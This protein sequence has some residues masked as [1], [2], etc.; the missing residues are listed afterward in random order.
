MKKDL[1]STE[2]PNRRDFIKGS[3]IAAMMALMGGV[4]ITAQDANKL[5]A[6][7]KADPNFKE[8]PPGP[9]VKLGVIGLGTWGKELIATAAR[10]PNGPVV[11][12]SDT[13]ES[14]LRRV[15]EGAPNT[16]QHKGYL[17]SLRNKK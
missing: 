8:K 4:E 15:R 1:S 9:P 17:G 14:S 6:V 16:S 7:P 2:L 13:Y 10:L 11:A 5:L 3:S 12:V